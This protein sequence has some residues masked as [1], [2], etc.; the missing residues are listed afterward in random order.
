MYYIYFEAPAPTVPP[1]IVPLNTGEENCYQV[2]VQTC[3][4]TYADTSGTIA[5]TGY[6][7]FAEMLESWPISKQ[8]TRYDGSTCTLWMCAPTFTLT[9]TSSDGWCVSVSVNGKYL[10]PT[11][12]LCKPNKGQ[13]KYQHW[14]DRDCS[15]G[16]KAQLTFNYGTTTTTPKAGTTMDAKNIFGKGN[17]GD[18]V[19]VHG[20]GLGAQSTNSSGPTIINHN[21]GGSR[22]KTKMM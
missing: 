15:H 20:R 12:E 13:K 17:G 5:A 1:S 3:R 16:K 21:S 9:S 6:G 8:C 22:S 11:K 7:P 10:K 14:L 18:P 4:V 19:V 2:R